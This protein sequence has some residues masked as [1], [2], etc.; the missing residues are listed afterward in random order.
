ML[1]W[2]LFSL[3]G[4]VAPFILPLGAPRAVSALLPLGAL[5]AVLAFSAARGTT[6]GFCGSCDFCH[7]SGCSGWLQQAKPVVTIVP[8]SPGAL[9][10]CRTGEGALL[11]ATALSR[12]DRHPPCADASLTPVRYA[13][14]SI[15]CRLHH[16]VGDASYLTLAVLR[17]PYPA[18]SVTRH[19]LDNSCPE[20]LRWF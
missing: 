2:W 9:N 4:V 10:A 5:R 14:Q 20:L 12:C 17:H 11:L 18:P 1:A 19:P 7:S 16:H 15:R 3:A 8:N 6:N 13:P